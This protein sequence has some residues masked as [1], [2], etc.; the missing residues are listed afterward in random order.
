MRVST[1]PNTTVDDPAGFFNMEATTTHMSQLTDIKPEIEEIT[2]A[3]DAIN[4]RLNSGL[5][6][7]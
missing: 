4:S 3:I 1:I 6:W 7:L 5:R 2:G